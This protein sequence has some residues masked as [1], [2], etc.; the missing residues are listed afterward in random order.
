MKT[1]VDKEYAKYLKSKS[2]AEL[3]DLAKNMNKASLRAKHALV[4]KQIT[5][6]KRSQGLRSKF[7]V[8][9][10]I[11]SSETQLLKYIVGPLPIIV[12]GAATLNFIFSSNPSYIALFPA[13]ILLLFIWLYKIEYFEYRDIYLDSESLYI[14]IWRSEIQIPIRDIVNIHESIF[15]NVRPITLYLKTSTKIG[16]KVT[17]LPLRN[18]FSNEYDPTVVALLQHIRAGKDF[19]TEPQ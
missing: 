5:Y 13:A 19:I 12:T 4:K 9:T 14:K 15:T 17:F 3:T 6:L 10:R 7:L 16:N 18:G 11:S 2:L 1:E 8:K